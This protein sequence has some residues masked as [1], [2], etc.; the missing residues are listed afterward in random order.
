M[1]A[2]AEQQ[3]RVLNRK[4]GEK[5]RFCV[6]C[7]CPIVTF[8]RLS[9]CLHVFC[10]ICAT[11]MQ[12]CAICRSPIYRIERVMGDTRLFISPLTLQSFKNEESLRQHT[13]RVHGHVLRIQEA[14]GEAY[15]TLNASRSH[16]GPSAWSA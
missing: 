2:P 13:K 14:H 8:G 11:D 7:G 9:P 6:I 5:V 3:G 12:S 15:T 4:E 1:E 16:Y 10:L